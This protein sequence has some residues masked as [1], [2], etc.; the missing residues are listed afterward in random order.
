MTNTL[1]IH[2]RAFIRINREYN[3]ALLDCNYDLADS[4]HEELKRVFENI[5]NY[6]VL[7]KMDALNLKIEKSKHTEYCERCEQHVERYITTSNGEY[8]CHDCWI[9][10]E[11]RE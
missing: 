4:L 7:Y 6:D 9:D 1:Q 2:V 5:K 10:G 11:D 8:V 3:E